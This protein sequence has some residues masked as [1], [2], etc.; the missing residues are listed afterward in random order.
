M[1]RKNLEMCFRVHDDLLFSIY[2]LDPVVYW[3]VKGFSCYSFW[4]VYL[5]EGLEGISPY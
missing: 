3:D 2:S 1:S 4:K 5:S